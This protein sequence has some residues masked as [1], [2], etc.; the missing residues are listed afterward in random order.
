L[1]DLVARIDVP[2]LNVISIT[3]FNQLVFDILQLP[4]L[5]FRTKKFTAFNRA[6]VVLE[7]NSV[8]VTLSLQTTTVDTAMLQLETSCRALD[9][10][11]SSLAQVCELCLPT[12][13][14]LEHLD[15]RG[16]PYLQLPWQDDTESAQWLELLQPFVTVKN[17]YLSNKVAYYVSPALRGLDG[18]RATEMLPAL[19]ALV[20]D[21][22][23]SSGPVEGA[24]RE[25][26]AARQLSG[27]PVAIRFREGGN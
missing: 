5:V 8:K 21:G 15:I 16:S 11:L 23:Q 25:F 1:E 14:N 13:Y 4:K 3:F 26:V 12:L 24:F 22:P 17:L 20:L 18:E 19:Q 7:A 27:H 6:D 2:L 10:Q 9:W